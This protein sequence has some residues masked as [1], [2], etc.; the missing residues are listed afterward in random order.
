MDQRTLD[1]YD[2]HAVEA[3]ARYRGVDQSAWQQR[4]R[5]VF[6]PK[7]RVTDGYYA[8]PWWQAQDG[9]TSFNIVTYKGIAKRSPDVVRLEF[10]WEEV[11]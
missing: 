1:Y 4:F 6:P 8:A 7:A 9:R 11:R 2:E 5:E 10:D 3:A